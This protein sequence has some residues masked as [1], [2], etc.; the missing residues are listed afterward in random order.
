MLVSVA[1]L[2]EAVTRRFVEAS[3][4]RLYCLPCQASGRKASAAKR[5]SI[6]G[7]HGGSTEGLLACGRAP[8]VRRA[9]QPQGLAGASANTQRDC[10]GHWQRRGLL[11]I[12]QADVMNDSCARSVAEAKGAAV[13]PCWQCPVSVSLPAWPPPEL[14][15]SGHR[16]RR[17]ARRRGPRRPE[18]F[19]APHPARAQESS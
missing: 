3:L 17:R 12:A 13:R 16:T 6:C 15:A 14:A 10:C 9:P 1:K 4:D 2:A 11:H 8:E 5:L 7:P 18:P 19:P